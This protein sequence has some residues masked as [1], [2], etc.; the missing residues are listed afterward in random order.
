[1]AAPEA[2]PGSSAGLEF[3]YLYVPLPIPGFAADMARRAEELGFDVCLFGDTQSLA[4][5]PYAAACLAAHT[6]SRIRLGPGVTNPITRSAAATASSI[7]TVQ[8][9]SGGRAILGLGRGDS[10]AA[11]IG[12]RPAATTQLESYANALRSYLA[13][14]EPGRGLRRI[15]WIAGLPKIPLDIACTGP[16]TIKLAARVADRVTFAVG[17]APERLTWALDI[18]RAAALD[19]GR[20]LNDIQFGAYLN[21]IVHPDERRARELART[22]VGLIAHFSSMPGARVEHLPEQL[23]PTA[24]RLA[25]EYDM[26]A[27]GR[28]AAPQTRLLDD[29]FVDWFAIAGD[30]SRCHDR[31]AELAE[32]GLRHAYVISGSAE[33]FPRPL[34]ESQ[35][36]LAADVMPMLARRRPW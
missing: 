9:E 11:F 14:E 30:A 1:M 29:E 26:S 4:G 21:V 20:D 27:H 18:A 8:L 15:D 12:Q 19:A 33:S 6:T 23:R 35:E 28:D 34:L 25:Q 36:R 13:G 5:D 31:L 17:A 7:A 10:A 2:V 22:G 16:S 24:E 3:G 32:L